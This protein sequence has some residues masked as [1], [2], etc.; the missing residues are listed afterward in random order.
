MRAEV[1]EAGFCPHWLLMLV[2]TELRGL[3][4]V[5]FIADGINGYENVFVIFC[6]A[7][8]TAKNF[9]TRG[10]IARPVSED[11]FYIWKPFDITA[12]VLKFPVLVWRPDP[13]L[14]L[15]GWRR[16]NCPPRRRSV[17]ARDR[18]CPGRRSGSGQ[19]RRR[20]RSAFV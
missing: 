19:P 3:S 13:S 20:I 16:P 2:C 8:D 11:S 14:P 9:C 18:C 6:P 4:H 1:R 12:A 7:F 10:N 15:S 5:L 17:Y